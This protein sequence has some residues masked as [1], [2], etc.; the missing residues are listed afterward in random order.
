[1]KNYIS[2]ALILISLFPFFL[3][4]P[5]LVIYGT[6]AY[7][8]NGIVEQVT[9]EAEMVGGFTA[10]VDE[11]YEEALSQYGLEDKGFSVHY[12]DTGLV[13]HKGKFVVQVRGSYTFQAFNLLGT[14]IGH[15]T[16]PIV[17]TDSGVSEVWIR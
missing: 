11:R 7:K 12:S 1:M 3:L 17:A 15:F 2:Y 8:A 13:E 4:I 5:D 9:K 10:S 6:Q 16:L 14:G